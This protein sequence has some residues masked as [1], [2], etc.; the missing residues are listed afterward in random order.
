V[1][2]YRLLRRSMGPV[3]AVHRPQLSRWFRAG[4]LVEEVQR[5]PEIAHVASCTL[6]DDAWCRRRRLAAVSHVRFEVFT[7]VIMK[8]AV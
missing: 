3:A 7:A 1:F 2:D 8:M 6:R 5:S 4:G